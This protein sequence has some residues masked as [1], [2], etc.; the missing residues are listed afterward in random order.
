MP[1]T[2]ILMDPARFYGG[3]VARISQKMGAR[4]VLDIM[5]LWPE[6]FEMLVTPALR[7]YARA[8]LWPLYRQRARLVRA[9]DALVGVTQDYVDDVLR[10]IE[11]RGPKHVA[12]LGW[13]RDRGDATDIPPEVQ[14]AMSRDGRSVTIAAYVGTLGNN[15]DI[16]TLVQAAAQLRDHAEIRWIIVGSGP[17]QDLVRNAVALFPPGRFVFLGQ[18]SAAVVAWLLARSDIGLCCYREGSTV[19]MPL[20]VY[21]YLAAGLPVV[22]SLK[23]EIGHLVTTKEIGLQYQ[24]GDACSLAQAVLRLADDPILRCQC[25]QRAAECARDLDP[26]RQHHEY[27][28]FLVDHRLI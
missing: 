11:F 3:V 5:D 24:A 10:G 6:I 27:V 4:L 1:A 19:S 18:Q 16:E 22:N 21:D 17:H 8:L 14:T 25:A 20:K 12:Y 2:V 26:K 9:A 28:N 13:H 7:F 23:R 15:Y